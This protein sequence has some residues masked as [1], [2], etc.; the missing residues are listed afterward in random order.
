MDQAA[1]RALA[2]FG[3]V[4]RVKRQCWWIHK[5]DEV[6]IRTAAIGALVLLTIGVAVVGFGG[7]QLQ[8]NLAFRHRRAKRATR[9]AQPAQKAM[10]DQQRPPEI[11]GLA[12]L[13][14]PS[15]PAKDVE[16]QVYMFSEEPAT[17]GQGK[18]T[19]VVVRRLHTDEAGRFESGVLQSGEYCLLGPLMGPDG[20]L[21]EQSRLFTHL[22]S[23]PLYLVAGVRKSIVDLNLAASTQVRLE[24]SGIPPQH[25]HRRRRGC[26]LGRDYDLSGWSEILRAGS[27][28]SKPRT[29]AQWLAVSVA[30]TALQYRRRIGETDRPSQRLV[31]SAQSVYV[32][33]AALIIRRGRLPAADSHEGKIRRDQANSG[34]S[35]HL[36]GQ[37]GRRLIAGASRC[38]FEGLSIEPGRKGWG[39]GFSAS[40]IPGILQAVAKG[41]ELKVDVA[42]QHKDSGTSSSGDTSP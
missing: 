10:L 36:R 39:R 20:Q 30:V 27:I 7:W 15:R 42:I 37:H 25:H 5:G 17:A 24:A 32:H 8:R 1:Q 29:A 35:C 12:Y 16:I 14:D 21:S 40:A 3:D 23:R 22:Q 33:S 11:S 18:P 2:Q 4:A 26:S 9:L 28:G 13:G 19:G 34:R 41:I 31:A 38:G 6:M